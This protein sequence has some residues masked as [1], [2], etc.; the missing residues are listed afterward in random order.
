M[1]PSDN[2]VSEIPKPFEVLNKKLDLLIVK[3]L[4]I[5]ILLAIYDQNFGWMRCAP[6]NLLEI[7]GLVGDLRVEKDMPSLMTSYRKLNLPLA[8]GTETTLLP[9]K[10]APVALEAL[11]ASH[12]NDLNLYH[13]NLEIEMTHL[14]E[15]LN[16]EL[17][18]S[19]D[20]IQKCKLKLNS[21][22][23]KFEGKNLSNEDLAIEIDSKLFELTKFYIQKLK[24]EL[25]DIFK[26]LELEFT[27]TNGIVEIGLENIQKQKTENISKL[28]LLLDISSF[29]SKYLKKI[30]FLLEN[31][32]CSHLIKDCQDLYYQFIHLKIKGQFFLDFLISKIDVEAYFQ[33]AIESAEE[34]V[35][36]YWQISWPSF[37][38]IFDSDR[39]FTTCCDLITTR[40]QELD[41]LQFILAKNS[42][43]NIDVNSIIL[44]KEKLN[45]IIQF[46]EFYETTHYEWRS[47]YKNFCLGDLS[48][49]SNNL[50]EVERSL[51]E[52]SEHEDSLN[53]F[54]KIAK[55]LNPETF[56]CKDVTDTIFKMTHN[57]K[58]ETLNR[59]L[60]LLEPF[61]VEIYKKLNMLHPIDYLVILFLRN[62]KSNDL[63]CEEICK[64]DVNY[65]Q[66]AIKNYSILS[67][68]ID[69]LLENYHRHD[70][71][72][73][74][75]EDCKLRISHFNN[76]LY[77]YD[78]LGKLPAL[79]ESESTKKLCKSI[80]SFQDTLSK[81]RECFTEL[82]IQA[83]EK[84]IQEVENQLERG[85][86]Y[87]ELAITCVR[88]DKLI[89]VKHANYFINHYFA[90]CRTYFTMLMDELAEI[91][92]KFFPDSH[93][94]LT[95]N[96]ALS[97]FTIF[98]EKQKQG[99][100]NDD[101]EEHSEDEDSL[102]IGSTIK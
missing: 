21:F 94:E 88:E 47:Y 38:N 15:A 44:L 86:S 53:Y 70:K 75:F 9:Q 97:K 3:N 35:E 68:L 17:G 57:I 36:I 100:F 51:G 62:E 32:Q 12:R 45:F 6:L 27:K 22:Q 60:E 7:I 56:F 25:T 101:V 91:K 5:Q 77:H 76:L 20:E 92:R 34:C 85:M 50:P 46:I 23:K 81:I 72:K 16:E 49:F 87:L 10:D 31:E 13:S 33:G 4:N 55:S 59:I 11:I 99:N 83:S 95:S 58:R 1:R 66:W 80:K 69:K 42:S 52:F 93:L 8:C 2:L 84:L 18:L 90:G 78:S 73:L 89:P 64:L 19:K 29:F 24:E 61:S 30:P 28:I 37:R 54:R 41:F 40:T 67:R 39:N 74:A 96:Q 43:F 48:I 71:A 14:W 102:K 82:D 79:I 98:N 26:Y 65:F 63:T